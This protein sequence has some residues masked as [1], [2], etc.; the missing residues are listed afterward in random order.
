MYTIYRK[1]D[2]TFECHV[3]Y[4]DGTERTTE[5]TMKKAIATVILGAKMLNNDTITKGDIDVFREV[6]KVKY[7]T[8]WVKE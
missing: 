8:E 5:P 6:E 2:G 7:V 3:R 1:N 4:Q